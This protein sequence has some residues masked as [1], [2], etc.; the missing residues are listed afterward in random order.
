LKSGSYFIHVP[1]HYFEHFNLGMIGLDIPR[2]YFF[3]YGF[4]A[5]KEQV[6]AFMF[7]LI[8]CLSMLVSGRFLLEQIKNL[9]ADESNARMFNI[10]PAVILPFMIFAIFMLFYHFG[11]KTAASV[12]E[13][14]QENDFN[15]YMRVKVW[16]KPPENAEYSA[17]MA[18][19]WQ[20]GCYRLLMQDKEYVYLF[21]PVNTESKIPVDMIPADKVEL[22]RI[23]PVNESCP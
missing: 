10:I 19:E 11:E 13:R 3:V 15:S 6:W 14:Q 7:F 23:L 2:E 20:K 18:K 4:Q 9:F 8:A 5:I 16:A 12:Y 17:E 21:Y 22:M 1:Y